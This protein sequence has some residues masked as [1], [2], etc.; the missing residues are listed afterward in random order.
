MSLRFRSIMLATVLALSLTTG[1]SHAQAPEP[2]LPDPDALPPP[3]ARTKLLAYGSGFLLGFYGVTLASSYL[4]QDDPGA[5][6]LRIP[7]LGP[8]LK[9]GQTRLCSDLPDT[10][11]PC[12]DATQIIGAVGVTFLGLGQF[13]SAF[14]LVEGALMKV[15]RGAGQSA[16]LSNRYRARRLQP[17]P[18]ASVA[19]DRGLS[20]GFQAGQIRVWPVPVA[21][22][23]MTGIGLVGQF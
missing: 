19:A 3:A 21:S 15:D 1:M 20:R 22:L 8:W 12:N 18:Q 9:L 14:F 2:T 11:R 5:S 7:F 10:G 16:N 13:A 23:H 4:W 17:A 6:D